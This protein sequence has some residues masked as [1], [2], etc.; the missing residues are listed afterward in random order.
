MLI[1]GS[2]LG[3]A[4]LS[5]LIRRVKKRKCLLFLNNGTLVMSVIV[6]YFT[7]FRTM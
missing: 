6:P 7:W 5:S 3:E 1:S 4:A 2:V